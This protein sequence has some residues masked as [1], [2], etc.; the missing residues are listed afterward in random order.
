VCEIFGYSEQR[1]AIF[2]A[3]L[4]RASPP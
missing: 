1:K 3:A 2:I 4:P